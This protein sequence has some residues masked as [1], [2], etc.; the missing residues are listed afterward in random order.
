MSDDPNPAHELVAEAYDL[1]EQ[2]LKQ[3]EITQADSEACKAAL[4]E[5]IEHPIRISG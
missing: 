3:D 5:A 2:T 1:M 4:L